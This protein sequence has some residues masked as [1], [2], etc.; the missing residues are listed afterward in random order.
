MVFWE[1]SVPFFILFLNICCHS[2]Q[3]SPN[4]C[5]V[6]GSVFFFFLL[7]QNIA[8]TLSDEVSP[9]TLITAVRI[10]FAV[11]GF[12]L[13]SAGVLLSNSHLLHCLLLPRLWECEIPVVTGLS[14][15]LA[16]WRT[17]EWSGLNSSQNVFL[18]WASLS[19]SFLNIFQVSL[20]LYHRGKHSE[21]LRHEQIQRFFYLDI[22]WMFIC[23]TL[24]SVQ[25]FHCATLK[26]YTKSKQKALPAIAKP[27]LGTLMVLTREKPVD[28]HIATS[29]FQSGHIPDF[30]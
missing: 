1:K 25:S 7:I 20:T 8:Y 22:Y 16:I 23:R 6:T 30:V 17:L 9:A 11:S 5:L 4:L 19:N 12:L 15:V 24:S 13:L 28:G 3:K 21:I 10:C 27:Y 14:S 2:R 18:F 29:R 26:S